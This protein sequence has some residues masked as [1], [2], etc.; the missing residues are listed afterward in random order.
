MKSAE[1]YKMENREKN[2]FLHSSRL[3]YNC[4]QGLSIGKLK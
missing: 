3:I 1:L 2:F 4:M